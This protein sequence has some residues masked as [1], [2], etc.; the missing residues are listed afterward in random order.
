[1][2]EL[3]VKV[4]SCGIER[5]FVSFDTMVVK[6]PGNIGAMVEVWG[7]Y[8][9]WVLELRWGERDFTVLVI[10]NREDKCTR[11]LG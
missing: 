5:V 8:S 2:K 1:M 11:K 9:D 3:R 6:R 10:S 7:M 4:A